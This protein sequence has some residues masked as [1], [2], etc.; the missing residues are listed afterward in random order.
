MR[1]TEYVA[2]MAKRKLEIFFK[3]A[4]WVV[5]RFGQTEAYRS[6]EIK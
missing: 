1:L 3:R 5:D 6:I 2:C 4:S